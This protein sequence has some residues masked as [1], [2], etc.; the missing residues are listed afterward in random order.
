MFHV[1]CWRYNLYV[2][3]VSR[4]HPSCKNI[5][6][7]IYVIIYHDYYNTAKLCYGLSHTYTLTHTHTH[8]HTHTSTKKEILD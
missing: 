3:E 8:T 6:F 2:T 4:R 7:T 5:E 1:P